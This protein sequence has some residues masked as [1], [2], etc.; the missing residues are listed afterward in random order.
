MGQPITL[1]VIGVVTDVH[2]FGADQP[3]DPE[4]FLPYTLEVWP[5][6][7]FVARAPD[8]ERLLR[9]MKTAV[10]NTEPALRFRDEPAVMHAGVAGIDGQRR[11]I[12]LVLSGFAAGALLIAAVGLYG[13]VAYGVTQRTREIG[14]RI[15]LGASE[16]RVMTLVL[17]DGATFVLIGAAAG[18]AGAVVSARLIRA[19]LFETSPTDPATF[20][21]VTLLLVVVAI[22]AIYAPARRAARTDPTIAI[23]TE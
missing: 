16:G 22:V 13:M 2:E 14:V 10:R 23:R 1:P 21:T 5:W 17:R 11:F 6:M 8:A 19:M 4:V 15:A 9:A 3:P 18:L 20:A 12:T 7:N